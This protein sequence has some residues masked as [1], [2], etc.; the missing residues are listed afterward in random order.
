MW[1]YANKYL[2]NLHEQV[3]ARL[4]LQAIACPFCIK[5]IN[6]TIRLSFDYKLSNPSLMKK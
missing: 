1:L 6:T 3:E 5:Q 4:G 2:N